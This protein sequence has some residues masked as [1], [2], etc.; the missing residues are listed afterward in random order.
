MNQPG[1]SFTGIEQLRIIFMGTPEFAVASLD[2]LV[3][4]GCNIVAVVTAPDK[5]AGR[6]MKLTESAVKKYAVEQGL[7]ILQPEKLKNPG[8]IEALQLLKAD[9]QIVVAFRM[10]PEI[11]WSM[12]PLGTVNVHGSLLPQYRGAA[13]INWAVINGEKETG[14]TTFQLQQEIDT[15]NI[16]LQD[17]FP[18]GDDET[19]GEVHDRMKEVGAQ[20]LVK[21]IQGLVAHSIQ[22]QPQSSVDPQL[23]IKHAP[24]LFTE[25]CKIDWTKTADEIHNLIRGLSPYPTAFTYMDN[26]LMKIFHS[27]K[28]ITAHQKETGKVLSD[29][30]TYL[31]FSCSNGFIHILDMQLEGKKR[32][33]TGDFLR[34]YKLS[35]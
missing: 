17:S 31:K 12:P 6:G 14:V 33:L 34:G 26:K 2:A 10:L 4:S 13:P 29:G 21:T 15:G 27:S 24:K 7:P 20:L 18:I 5:P 23:I 25:T 3:K 22:A 11:V 9:I 30:K 8:F 1:N 32:M 35:E 28:E 16:L 19:A